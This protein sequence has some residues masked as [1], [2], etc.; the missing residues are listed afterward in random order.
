MAS[1]VKPRGPHSE[2]RSCL[3]NLKQMDGAK[4]QWALENKKPAGSPVVGHES[5]ITKFLR[6]GD[7]PLC[8]DGGKYS[9]EPIGA[10]PECSLD[11]PNHTL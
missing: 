1:F 9:L 11:L 7:L 6:G 4:E 3:A 5:E 10:N 8:P 2:R